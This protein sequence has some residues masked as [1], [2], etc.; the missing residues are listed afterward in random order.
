[1]FD[2]E[3]EKTV[4]M[5]GVRITDTR[6]GE[7]SERMFDDYTGSDDGE[8][9]VFTEV[10]ALFQ[11]LI[12]G[13]TAQGLTVRLYHYT[14]YEKTQMIALARKYEGQPGVPDEASV[15]AFYE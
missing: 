15:R 6:T 2:C 8:Y 1:D 14:A 9:R 11:S 12:V 3:S 13:I 4:Y 7:V 5:W 10:W